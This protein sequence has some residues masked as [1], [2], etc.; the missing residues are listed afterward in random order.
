MTKGVDF[1]IKTQKSASLKLPPQKYSTDINT[2]MANIL[3]NK[4]WNLEKELEGN[5]LFA[6]LRNSRSVYHAHLY[7]E[8]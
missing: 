2:A 5:L 1:T 7:F 3:F 8:R 6:L 4:F